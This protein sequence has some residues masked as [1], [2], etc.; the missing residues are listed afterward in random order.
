MHAGR[1][2]GTWCAWRN[3]SVCWRQPALSS[4][5]G[6]RLR[7]AETGLTFGLKTSAMMLGMETRHAQ[8][9]SSLVL[10]RRPGSLSRLRASHCRFTAVTCMRTARSTCCVLPPACQVPYLAQLMPKKLMYN[11][12]KCLP[13]A[14]QT[15]A[16][17]NPPADATHTPSTAASF[18]RLGLLRSRTRLS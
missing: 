18:W 3:R 1:S 10:I 12:S 9:S 16:E 11:L 8:Q 2:G 14:D 15:P 7:L 6:G 5:E 17:N 4:A 13:P